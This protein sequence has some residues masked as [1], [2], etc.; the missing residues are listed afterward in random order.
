MTSPTTTRLRLPHLLASRPDPASTLIQARI[1]VN[2]LRWRATLSGLFARYDRVKADERLDDKTRETALARLLD[3]INSVVAQ[4][5]LQ[6]DQLELPGRQ[7]P[8]LVD[9]AQQYLEALI[10][11]ANRTPCPRGVLVEDLVRRWLGEPTA[12]SAIA[13]LDGDWHAQMLHDLDTGPAD[14]RD[15]VTALAA[16]WLLDTDRAD[17][18]LD[19]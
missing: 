9:S 19:E 12:V 1:A 16:S 11:A 7:P 3:T 5:P 2:L 14:V 6:L 10:L 4:E 17:A 18:A 15:A 8:E 13:A